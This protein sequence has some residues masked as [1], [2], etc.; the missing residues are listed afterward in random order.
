MK[1]IIIFSFLAIG[2][3]LA[4]CSK[5]INYFYQVYQTYIPSNM[6]MEDKNLYFE[7]KNVKVSYDL[8]E[9]GGIIGFTFYNKTDKLIYINME[10]TF[11]IKN[12]LAYNYFQQRIFQTSQANT[13]S[14]IRSYQVYGFIS[15]ELRETNS[16]QSNMN[17]EYRLEERIVSI[18]PHSAKVISQYNIVDELLR[19]CKLYRFPKKSPSAKYNNKI[20]FTPEESPLVFGN[21]ITYSLDNNF[22]TPII[23]DNTFKVKSIANYREK[24]VFRIKKVRHCDESYI[25]SKVFVDSVSTA[26]NFYFQYNKIKKEKDKFKH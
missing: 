9:N 12:G 18:P 19:D 10:E 13:S 7:D 26:N 8:W 22:E 15:P 25:S 5:K 3:T 24:D 4:S 16:I 14:Q 23:I 11:F 6:S 2:L 21:R 20:E 1:R 17:S